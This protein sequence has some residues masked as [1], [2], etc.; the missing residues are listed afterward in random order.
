MKHLLPEK[1]HFKANLHTHST[2][3]GGKLTPEEI[4]E[5]Y[6][7]LG[8]SILAITD[9]CAMIP[10][11]DL[12]DPDFLMVTGMEMDIL[13]S[14][15]RKTCHLCF[16][17]RDPQLQWIPFVD[18]TAE[19]MAPY[20]AQ[21]ESED[22]PYVYSPENLN[23]IIA[24]ANEKGM[25]VTYNH[26]AWSQEYYPDYSVYE[27]LWALEYR[28]ST[29]IAGGTDENNGWVFREFINMG[30]PLMPIMADDMHSR[31]IPRNGHPILGQSWTV[32]ATDKLEYGCV[33][34]AL[35]RGDLYASCGPEIHSLIWDDGILRV[36][37]SPATR[38]Q[39]IKNRR[40]NRQDW[41]EDLTE[42]AFDMRQWLNDSADDP[43]ARFFLI[44]TDAQGK[45][46]VTR[47][48]SPADLI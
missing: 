8:Y 38:I 15:A 44:I 17:S 12:T 13:Q 18:P 25:L 45:Y 30:K 4:K 2:I 32:V 31:C 24:K 26:P 19:S 10:H 41:G 46:A 48:Y 3:S 20:M 28:N 42:A 29:C 33:M 36:K 27:G 5:A 14:S 7:E 23:R 37:C 40:P 9:H 43:N 34:D 39:L 47:S 6:K 16:L 35:A 11:T 21:C 1:P 22:F